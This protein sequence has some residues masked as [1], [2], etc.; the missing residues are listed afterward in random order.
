[1]AEKDRGASENQAYAN[2]YDAGY[3]QGFEDARAY[4]L[5]YGDV[6]CWGDEKLERDA[7]YERE[8]KER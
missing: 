7:R 3:K 1:M 4:Y 5:R 6:P 2:G 8:E